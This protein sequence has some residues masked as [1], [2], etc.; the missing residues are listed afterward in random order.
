MAIR[1]PP[2]QNRAGEEPPLFFVSH[3]GRWAAL[4]AEEDVF[5]FHLHGVDSDG[6]LRTLPIANR[7][8]PALVNRVLSASE[9]SP[10]HTTAATLLHQ[11]LAQHPVTGQ[12]NPDRP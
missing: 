1:R 4:R 11:L 5:F 12:G 7:N 3:L 6:I 9:S 8:D 2:S 10:S